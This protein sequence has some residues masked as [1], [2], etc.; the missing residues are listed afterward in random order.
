MSKLG[1]LQR[2]SQQLPAA[3]QTHQEARLLAQQLDSRQAL[4]I[5]YYNLSEDYLRN[6]DYTNTEK[7]GQAALMELNTL[8]GMEKWKS[9]VFNTLGVLARFRGDL[10]ISAQVLQQAVTIERK[11]ERRIPLLRILN[12]L[13]ITLQTSG[14][15]DAALQCYEEASELLTAVPYEIDKIMIQINLGALYSHQKQ[16]A[17]AEEN[18]RLINFTYLNQ[19]NKIYYEAAALQ[20]L[21]NVILKQ[22][23]AEE[24]T[25]Y[26]QRAIILWKTI[27]EEI[28]QA[29][30]METLGEVFVAQGQ[31]AK[32]I[33]LYKKAIALLERFPDNSR[34]QNL[35]SEFKLGLKTLLDEQ[36]QPISKN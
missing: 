3:I 20:S 8:E 33:P 15:I 32:A 11:L 2:I 16:W 23:R 24:A 18:L 35:R 19:S 29:N 30:S 6:H 21:G 12:N 36:K 31:I 1:Q 9:S 10:V 34:S 28:E 25:M 22:G 13:A 26:L 4:S 27:D 14:K 7:Y 5:A 17:K